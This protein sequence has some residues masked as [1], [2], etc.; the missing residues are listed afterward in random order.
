MNSSILAIRME[1]RNPFG[2][3]VVCVVDCFEMLKEKSFKS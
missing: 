3:N 1:F 2:V